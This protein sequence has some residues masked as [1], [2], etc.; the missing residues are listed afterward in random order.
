MNKVVKI[1]SGN[2]PF[3]VDMYQTFTGESNNDS[4]LDYYN[5]QNDTS[6]DYNDFDWEYN[7]KEVLKGLSMASVEYIIENTN[8]NIIKNV[9]LVGT[10][11]PQFYN[12]NTDSY[13]MN[14]E[15]DTDK[16]TK[17]MQEN[18]KE[19]ATWANA[20]SYHIPTGIAEGITDDML[21]YYLYTEMN[22]TEDYI[23][24]MYDVASELWHEN[25]EMKLA[26]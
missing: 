19:Y 3:T 21:S 4:M 13:D 6:L 17:Y 14:I 8:E 26:Q 11:S 16:F 1:N 24:S 22:D 15:V 7:T 23:M 25:T 12:Y 18:E 9:E 10:F 20:Q 5:S 2:T